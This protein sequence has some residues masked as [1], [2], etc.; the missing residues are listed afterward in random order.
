MGK[1]SFSKGLSPLQRRTFTNNTHQND[2]SASRNTELL[3]TGQAKFVFCYKTLHQNESHSHYNFFF[4]TFNHQRL[5][6]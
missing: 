6:N 4:L 1:I 5:G 3:K 2:K